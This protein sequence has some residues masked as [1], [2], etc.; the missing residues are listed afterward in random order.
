MLIPFANVSC[1]WW[2]LDP[3]TMRRLIHVLPALAIVTVV[4]RL[5]QVRRGA[6]S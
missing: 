5:I 4:I 1:P 2:S 3:F 6:A